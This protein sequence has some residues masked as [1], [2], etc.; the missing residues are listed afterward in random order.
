MPNW[1][2]MFTGWAKGPLA[3]EQAKCDNAETAIRKALKASEALSDMDITVFGQ[4]SYRNK[5]NVRQNSDVDICV[6]LN[7]TFFPKYPDGK[8]HA[9]FGNIDGTV[10]FA[11]YRNLVQEALEDYL[12]EDSVT[13][14]D[15]AF[16]IHENTY[17][18]DADAVATFEHRRYVLNDDG[19][20]YYLSGIGFET[21]AGKR[22]LNWPE[23]HY[24]SGL[25]KHEATGRRYRKMIRILKRL[26]DRMQD[27]NID[28][29]SNI[30]SC[31]IESMVWNVPDEGFG[32]DTYKADIRY[33]LAHIFNNTIKDEQC[34]K[35]VEV[36]QL[37]YLFRPS[38]PW[39]RDAAHKFISAAWDYIGFS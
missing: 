3:T 22:I 34:S 14:G 32:H 19:S 6:R 20:F 10:T 37:K 30:A 36:S 9:D 27:E 18:I 33:V 7:S 21:D 31:L 11:D 28:A 39:T 29:A 17:R 16:T 23:Q 38:Q 15:K 8:S 26:R 35:W 24:Q 1:E 2:E 13:R 12:G 4:G 5:T 25:E